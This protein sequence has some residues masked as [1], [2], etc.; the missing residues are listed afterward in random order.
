MKK[1]LVL[2]TC[3]LALALGAAAQTQI[4]FA[5]LPQ[6]KLPAPMPSGYFGF[7]WSNIYYVDPALWSGAGLGYKNGLANQDVAFVGSSTCNYLP[8]NLN[9][10]SCNG[11]ISVGSSGVLSFQALSASVAA[12]FSPTSF[13]VLAYNNGTYVGTAFFA[14]GTQMQTIYFPA[15]WGNITELNFQTQGEGDLVFYGLNA[16]LILQ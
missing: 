13:T 9:H 15:S 11:T 14:I 3:I 6:V 1:V 5:Q 4:N 10:S 16:E 12:G 7:N 2:T 8:P